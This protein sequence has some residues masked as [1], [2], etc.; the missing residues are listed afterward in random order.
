MKDRQSRCEFIKTGVT[1]G[2]GLVLG[3]MNFSCYTK[4][5]KTKSQASESE[6]PVSEGIDFSKQ[7]YCSWNCDE[8]EC[9]ILRATLSNDLEAK[10]KIARRWAERFGREFTSEE[11][12]CYGCKVEDKPIAYALE[13]C[14][15]R[16]C[17]SKRDVITCAHCDELP[18]CDNE[19]W[20]EWPGLKKK[21]EELRNKLQG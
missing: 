16:K 8:K 4:L 1:V 2:T 5:M 11:I 13:V 15:V 7:A 20:T 19:L 17:A 10:K 18:T 14:T 9:Q 6:S 3:S 12:F 21:A